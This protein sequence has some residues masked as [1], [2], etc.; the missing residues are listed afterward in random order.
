MHYVT[1]LIGISI[2]GRAVAGVIHVPFSGGKYTRK[3][4]PLNVVSAAQAALDARAA[5]GPPGQTIWG[6]VGVGVQGL[7]RLPE[8]SVVEGRR[9]VTT[10]RTHF[11]PAL[12]ALLEVMK[13][14]AVVRCG[15]AG[16]KGL[17]VMTREVDAYVYPQAGTKRWD[18]CAIDACT[19]A[20]GGT[21]TDQYG[22][23]IPYDPEAKHDNDKGLLATLKNHQ[24]YVLPKP[25]AAANED[26]KKAN[27]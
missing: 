7:D 9:I 11:S 5:L 2:R 17:L 14:S 18:T 26:A 1:V 16:S 3:H 4:D 21:F 12:S 15:G 8:S 19:K 24:L 23:E 25:A 6:C 22:D 20:L 13:P 27:L 10:T